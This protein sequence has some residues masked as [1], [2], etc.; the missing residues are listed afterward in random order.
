VNSE[1]QIWK[2]A[3]SQ[4]RL[5]IITVMPE[6]YDL[7]HEICFE[8]KLMADI[9][10]KFYPNLECTQCNSIFV[11]YPGYVMI[12]ECGKRISNGADQ[13]WYRYWG[14]SVHRSLYTYRCRTCKELTIQSII[15]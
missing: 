5:D 6:L 12:W 3:A 9:Q 8:R 4:H 1:D 15:E 13:V 11:I 14:E 7:G 2:E 10:D